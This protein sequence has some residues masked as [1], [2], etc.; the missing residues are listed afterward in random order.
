MSGRIGYNCARRKEE[1]MNKRLRQWAER[2]QTWDSRLKRWAEKIKTVGLFTLVR[3]IEFVA[4]II[5]IVA[6]FSEINY[7]DE[8]RTDWAWQSLTTSAPGDRGKVKA[9]KYLNSRNISLAG[10][11]LTPPILA[12]QWKQKPKKDR[13]LVNGCE[14]LT[15]LRGVKLPKAVL[16]EATL[17]CAD[18]QGADLREAILL[19]A[20]LRGALLRDADLRGAHLL[21]A[22][23]KGARLLGADL[24]GA[25][26]IIPDPQM[27]TV[28][29]RYRDLQE[30][31]CS[32]LR[33]ARN[34]ESAHRD[35][36]LACGKPI[37]PAPTS[38]R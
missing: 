36:E 9:L 21:G 34:W 14:Q 8:K 37:L 7:R 13:E 19:G 18:L 15:Y 29:I 1:S 26:L 20:D 30:L 32:K 4:V 35:E 5:V 2:I 3:V 10:I 6:F 11:D 31:A 12:E 33:Q 17:V 38:K 24:R 22:K 23:L 28:N 25:H 16:V 27:A